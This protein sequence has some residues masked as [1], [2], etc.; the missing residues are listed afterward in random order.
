MCRPADTLP[1]RTLPAPGTVPPTT[2]EDVF[3]IKMPSA[4]LPT[5]VSPAAAVPIAFPWMT[6]PA[7]PCVALL[8]IET[9]LPALPE[10]TLRAPETVPPI[11]LAGES[12][13]VMPSPR[14][15]R[16]AEPARLVPIRLT[17]TTLPVAP[18]D[19]VVTIARPLPSLPEM[20][21]PAPTA[22]RR[23]C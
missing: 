11:V 7:A 23:S 20:D 5:A 9:P 13:R 10:M 15:A 16:A 18:G 21:V 4:P 14:F 22:C 17:R 6:F 1:E 3:W 12:L 19:W 8:A 2:V